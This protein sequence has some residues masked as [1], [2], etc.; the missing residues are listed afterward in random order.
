MQLVNVINAL[1]SSPA[2]TFLILV[3]T[4]QDQQIS[5]LVIS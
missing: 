4:D 5:G 2:G 3:A 1:V